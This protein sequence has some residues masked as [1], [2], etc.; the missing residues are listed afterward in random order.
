MRLTAEKNPANTLV[1]FPNCKINLGLRVTGKRSDGYH[2]LDTVFYPLP[3]KDAL[4]IMVSPADATD[5][6][7]LHTYGLPLPGEATS[8][9]CIKAWQLLKKNLPD[10]PPVQIHLLKAIPPGA[11]LGGGSS[12]GAFTLTLL[13]DLLHLGLEKETLLGLALQLGSDC[14]F[15]I[16][17]TPCHATGRGELLAE[18]PL[19]LNDYYFVLVHP[20]IHIGT[21]W[22]FSKIRAAA[23]TTS[24]REIVVQPVE[25]WQQLLVN[26]FEEAVFPEYPLLRS[27]KETLY[28]SG[29]A[30]ASLTG[31]GSCIYGIFP[32]KLPLPKFEFGAGIQVY[33][34]NYNP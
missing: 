14:P 5:Q 20:G 26:D 24:T 34:L 19:H 32:N 9:L 2:Q 23:V 10:L 30:Y 31:T 3:L 22:A 1:L 16:H 21:A 7:V 12:N 4:E 29:A 8:N 17:N 13:N 25:S 6:P 28:A 27:I 15:F 11:G 18:V 33:A